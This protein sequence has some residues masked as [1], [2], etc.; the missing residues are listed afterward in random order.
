VSDPRP[1]TERVPLSDAE[2]RAATIGELKPLDSPILLADYDPH[3]PRLF[4]REAARIRRALGGRALRIEHVGSTSVPGI[5]AKPIID[6]VLVVADSADEQA[7]VPPLE[8][9]GYVL[10]IREPEWFEHRVL[11]G[12][13]TNV[14]LWRCLGG[15][16]LDDDVSA[17]ARQIRLRD[18]RRSS[19]LERDFDPVVVPADHHVVEVVRK[20]PIIRIG[21]DLNEAV[22]VGLKLPAPTGVRRLLANRELWVHAVAPSWRSGWLAPR[23]LDTASPP[24]RRLYQLPG[25]I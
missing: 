13:D 8:A 17:V 18:V 19:A 21:G 23:S 1:D 9:A 12:S 14:N 22:G 10:R 25:L 20:R 7:Y 24:A 6:I 4:E 5:A 11:K 3:W 15:L 2:I 16:Q